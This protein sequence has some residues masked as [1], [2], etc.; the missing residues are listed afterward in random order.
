MPLHLEN[1]VFTTLQKLQENTQPQW[2]RMT[3]QHMI[4][5]LATSVKQS[6]GK[7]RV[8]PTHPQERL[9]RSKAFMLSDRPFPKNVGTD[10]E[11]PAPLPALRNA[12]LADAITELLNE[13]EDYKTHHLTDRGSSY[14]HSVF[15]Y[16]NKEEW[17]Y[18]HDKHFRHHLN[19]FG[20][21]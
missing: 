18:F 6:N 3:A 17:D 11:N 20:L 10:A 5:H 8:V 7:E 14:A 1:S 19:Q 16:L 21:I 2:G 15:G 12:S 4:E 13:V 9:D